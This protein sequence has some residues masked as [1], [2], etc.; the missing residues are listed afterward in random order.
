VHATLGHEALPLACRQFP[1]VSVRD[2]RGVSV[3]LSHY[4]PTAAA[5]LDDDVPFAI[6]IHPPGFPADGEYDGIDAA[7]AMPPLLRPDMLMDW[8]SWWTFEALSIEMLAAGTG[9]PRGPALALGRLRAAVERLREWQPAT[10][11]LL[12]LVRSTMDAARTADVAPF[13]LTPDER[14][15][16]LQEIVQATPPHLAHEHGGLAAS[17]PARTTPGTTARFL[18]AHAF[19]NWHI[20]L[21]QGLRTWLRSIEAAHA[22]LQ[23]GMDVG[24]ADLW[25]RHLAD[26]NRLARTWSRTE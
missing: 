17:G 26:V 18:A 4:C 13:A 22:L 21:G 6:A 2:P 7:R 5:M 14:S 10:G 8:E 3:T 15:L 16:R 9:E 19:A 24:E 25:L 12:S 1:R 11:P 20:Q 23:I